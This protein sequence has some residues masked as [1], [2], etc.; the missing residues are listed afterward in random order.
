MSWSTTQ[1]TLAA[2]QACWALVRAVALLIAREAFDGG[3]ASLGPT[4]AATATATVVVISAATATA[5]T[6]AAA[7]AASATSTAAAGSSTGWRARRLVGS[8][9]A[10]LSSRIACWN[11]LSALGATALAELVDRSL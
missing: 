1:V 3:S 9:G 8:A 2:R 4:V 7:S 6:A 5:A 11:S 10:A